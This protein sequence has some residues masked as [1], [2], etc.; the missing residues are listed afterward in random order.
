MDVM[1]FRRRVSQLVSLLT[2][3]LSG[4]FSLAFAHYPH[5]VNE[6]IALSPDFS[7]DATLFV[8]QKQASSVRPHV[9]L[10][11]KTGGYTWQH[12]PAGL[13]NVSKITSAATSALFSVD[14]TVMIATAADGIYRSQDAGGSWQHA[15]QGLNDLRLN[16]VVSGLDNNGNSIFYVS[17]QYGGLFRSTDLGIS[18]SEI[19]PVNNVIKA[20]AL[21]PDFSV[22]RTLLI[23]DATGSLLISHNKGNS[24][25]PVTL[26]EAGAEVTQIDF[27][28]D[29]QNVGAIFVGTT[30]GLY[31]TDDIAAG[32]YPVESY[33]GYGVS[34]LAVSPSFSIDRTLFTTSPS[35]GVFKSTD[36]GQ[37][38]V[39]STISKVLSG[40][41]THHYNNIELSDAFADDGVVFI[42][43]FEGL[44]RSDNAGLDWAELDHRPAGL[45]YGIAISPDY[46]QDGKIL[47]STYGGGLYLSDDKGANWRSSNVGIPD[48][49]TYQVRI[50]GGN[51]IQPLLIATQGNYSMASYDNG[52]S[53]V[54]TAI[55]GVLPGDC[56]PSAL[57]ISPDYMNDQTMYLGC[58]KDGL[59]RT[60]DAGYSWST[61]ISA[62]DMA[63]GSLVS[64]RFSPDFPVD[65]SIFLADSRGN[66]ARSENNGISW[67]LITNGLS[68]RFYG[69]TE[70]NISPGFSRDNFL[71]ASTANGLYGSLTR[72][73]GWGPLP[74]ISSPVAYGV[75]EAAAFSPDFVQDKTILVS[76][77]GEGLFRSVDASLSWQP[78]AGSLIENG[79]LLSGFVFSPDF[80]ND[81]VII[82]YAHDHLFRSRNRGDTFEL[83]DLPFIRHDDDRAQSVNFSGSWLSVDT[84]LANASSLHTT[85]KSGDES[86]LSFWGTGVSWIG[87]RA[88][89][90][91]IADVFLDGVKVASIDQYDAVQ[92]WQ[93]TLYS[94]KGLPEGMHE[95]R[96]VAKAD[97]NP[98]SSDN[99]TVIDAFD[100]YR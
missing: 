85:K 86:I 36:A 59:I 57:D 37:T 82:A 92:Y 74:D 90:L 91:G 94:I 76:V 20:F 7:S 48:V 15:N 25:S 18:W 93:Q 23:A 3:Y 61:S 54:A 88:D 8:A 95:I 78:V 62:D 16:D 38:W 84:E 60:E 79:H 1:I 34:G 63:G 96:I 89:N 100:V 21:S 31:F 52:G 9:A 51:G 40:Q 12:L 39:L 33:P 10:V 68:R 49:N 55:T 35:Q 29:F 17:G 71:L 58:R 66:F 81:G 4:M 41:T 69:G 77:R 45:I 72:G 50:T 19:V 22:D 28:P 56:I 13:D 70:I 24:F 42:A 83:F 75:I 30:T 65:R 6:F 97:K 80:K 26:P 64:V 53:W 14:R 47:V 46:K 87:M 32:F 2:V 73:T 99:W 5:D 44:F 27:A 11:S 98:A 67:R 43:M